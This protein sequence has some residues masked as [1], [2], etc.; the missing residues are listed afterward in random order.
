MGRALYFI[1]GV[2]MGTS[3]LTGCISNL[4]RIVLNGNIAAIRSF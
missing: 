3:V 2:Q 4:V 1:D